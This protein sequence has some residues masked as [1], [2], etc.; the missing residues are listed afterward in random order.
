[1]INLLRIWKIYL[2]NLR[3]A[4]LLNLV[5]ITILLIYLRFSF[6]YLDFF[7]Y[8]SFAMTGFFLTY[9]ILSRLLYWED[10]YHT[11]LLLKTL[12]IKTPVLAASRFLIPW[13][14]L[15]GLAIL[16]SVW[17]A[18]G[19]SEGF[20]LESLL[21]FFILM[22]F[23]SIIPNIFLVLAEYLNIMTV[24]QI[25]RVVPL[26]FLLIGLVIKNVDTEFLENLPYTLIFII[27]GSLSLVLMAWG[28]KKFTCRKDWH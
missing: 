6:P 12:P 1:M 25:M 9:S 22:I 24:L 13:S 8:V 20:T 4:L 2:I 28:W 10:K 27:A 18:I 19:S 17:L 15:S 3:N 5:I 26:S 14:I 21:I 16:H 23:L 11:L 7:P